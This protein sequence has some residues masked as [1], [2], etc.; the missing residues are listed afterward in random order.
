M[1]SDVTVKIDT[2]VH[3]HL[4]YFVLKF[5][6][7]MLQVGVY[8]KTKTKRAL[9]N[10]IALKYAPTSRQ[11]NHFNIYEWIMDFLRK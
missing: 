10:I 11:T 1:L 2:H 7:N 4:F 3:I 6:N 9:L 5:L 8:S